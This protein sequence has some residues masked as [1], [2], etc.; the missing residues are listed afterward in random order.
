LRVG[1]RFVQNEAATAA[2][3]ILQEALVN[4]ARHAEAENVTVEIRFDGDTLLLSVRDDGLGIGDVAL[5]SSHSIGLIGMR[6]RAAAL[7]GNVNIRRYPDGGTLVKLEL[8]L[9]RAYVGGAS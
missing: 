4:V 9:G 6:E 3:R 8:P 1:D 7:G 5:S 2:F